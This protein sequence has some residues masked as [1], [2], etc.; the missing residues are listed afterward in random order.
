[1][2]VS[3]ASGAR[4]V[5]SLEGALPWLLAVSGLSI[6]VALYAAFVYAPEEATMGQVQRIFYFHVPAAWIAFV[7]GIVGCVD[8][9]IV[10]GSIRWWRTVHPV[11]VDTG[12]FDMARPMLVA[13]LV[14][15]AA[16]TML[17]VVL[18]LVRVSLEHSKEDLER[19]R[20]AVGLQAE[21]EV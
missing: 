2:I 10:F 5:V 19:L 6:L 8:V 18:M 15:V 4:R 20:R 17:Y 21:E 16:F 12:G 3:K 7:L 13:L 14:S 1:M 9:P 11:V